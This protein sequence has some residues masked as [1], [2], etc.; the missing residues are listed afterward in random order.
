MITVTIPP[1]EVYDQKNN[2][3][4]KVD[5]P[6]TIQLEHSLISVQKWESKWGK[7]FLG[8]KKKTQAETIDYLRCMCM[9]PN[10]KDDI[11]YCIPQK[12][13]NRIASYIEAPM[14]ALVF[15][16]VGT[17]TTP[18]KREIVTADIIYYW[19]ISYNIPSEYR[20]WH[21]NQLLT[22]IQVFN[23]KNAPKKKRR[24]RM[25]ILNDYKS[26]NEANRA[27]FNTKG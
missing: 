27:L 23:E 1:S 21:L 4:Y 8:T 24:S 25:D 6:V 12:E 3:F 10:V 18:R 16:G 7:S 11:F 2:M 13:I 20:K 22:L 19:M 26:I 17:G 9:T 14:T 15:R 5:K